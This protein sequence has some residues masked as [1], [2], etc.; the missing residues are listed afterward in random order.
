MPNF[1]VAIV[2]AN[3]LIDALDPPARPS[4]PNIADLVTFE[5]WLA[6]RAATVTAPAWSAYTSDL[7]VF[8]RPLLKHA[9]PLAKV[10]PIQFLKPIRVMARVPL[11][12]RGIRKTFRC[13]FAAARQYVRDAFTY[14]FP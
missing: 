13:R 2:W 1:Y 3:S 9:L 10:P 5:D 14:V 12:K 11:G 8:S 7:S 6:L 4:T